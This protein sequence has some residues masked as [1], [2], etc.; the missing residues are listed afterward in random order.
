MYSLERLPWGP[1]TYRKVKSFPQDKMPIKPPVPNTCPITKQF[2]YT[3]VMI[4]YRWLSV[5]TIPLSPKDEEPENERGGDGG[6][7]SQVFWLLPPS[8]DSSV[9]YLNSNCLFNLYDA[10]VQFTILRYNLEDG[11]SASFDSPPKVGKNSLILFLPP[12]IGIEMQLAFFKKANSFPATYLFLSK[13]LS[14]SVVLKA[15]SNTHGVV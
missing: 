7:W 8:T 15:Q 13:G 14:S 3:I 11:W 1:E 10:L 12:K 4:T 5:I 6:T 2:P 9:V